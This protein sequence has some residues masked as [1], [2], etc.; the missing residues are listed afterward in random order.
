[1]IEP[2]LHE[3][4][5]KKQCELLNLS[6][7]TYYYKPTS[8]NNEDLKIM[9]IIDETYTMHPSHGMRRMAK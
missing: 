5:I 6:R 9:E 1:M 7:S 3:P 4:T 8:F 2:S